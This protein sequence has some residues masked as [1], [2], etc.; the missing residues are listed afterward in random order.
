M[1]P[2]DHFVRFYNEV[3]KFLDTRNGL[4]TYYGE[5]SRHQERHCLQL[6]REKGLQGMEEYW[7]HIRVE[8]NCVSESR[9]E[10][11]VRFSHMAKCPSLSKVLDSDAEPCAKYCEHCPG[12]VGPLMAKC[13]FYYVDNIFGEREPECRSFETKDRK[14]AEQLLEEWKIK[15]PNGRFRTNFD[16][17]EKMK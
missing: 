5:I 16:L 17:V 7:G 9:I 11:D 12:W 14:K 4:E 8:E 1:I 2:S 6:F 3:F 13:G 15:Y 10:G